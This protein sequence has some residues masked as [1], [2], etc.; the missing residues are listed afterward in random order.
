MA[1]VQDIYDTLFDPNTVC[2]A[3]ISHGKD[4]LAMLRAIKL[5]G[6]PL[7]RIVTSDVWATQD[8]PADLPPMWEWKKEADKRIKDLYGID[9]EHV[10][11]TKKAPVLDDSQIVQVEREREREREIESRTRECYTESCQ[12]AEN[13]QETSEDFLVRPENGA[14]S[15]RSTKL[16]YEDIF[17]RVYEGGER[18]GKM[19]GFPF[20]I[21][22][23]CQSRLK[24]TAMAFSESPTDEGRKTNII[25]YIGIAADEPE[26][27]KRH[28]VKPNIIM[29][30]VEIGWE[31]D[32]CGLIS[33]Y[34]DL[35][36]PVYTSATRD[37]CWFCHNQGVAQL[38]NLR[39]NY[40]ELW[41]LL[42]KWDADSP[43]TFK[44][45]GTTVHDFD[46]R[47]QL[48]DEGL[49]SPEDP[50]R[51]GY[52]KDLPLQLRMKF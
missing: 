5:L 27:I 20:N 41:S 11:A 51:W 1:W 47:F 38:R 48:E 24:Q 30:L 28:I 17:Y 44:A 6:L 35:L 50:W 49:I 13:T 19:Y 21:G 43:V 29:P 37:G 23:W 9:V 7:H 26:R 45:D 3:C 33:G 40:P 12:N 46:A 36:S 2:V 31:E 8:I 18:N 32:L 10:C 4:S 34:Q 42:L 15:S 25:Q 39:K 52:L 22:A 16:T 14:R